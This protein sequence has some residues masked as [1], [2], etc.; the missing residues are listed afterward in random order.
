[1]ER[2]LGSLGRYVQGWFGYYRISRTW[3]EVIELV[4]IFEGRIV[5]VGACGNVTGS[6]GDAPGGSGAGCCDWA[7]IRRRCIWRRAAA[8]AAGG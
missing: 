8:K 7:L 2:R 5:D 4:G 3:G 6:N 1:M